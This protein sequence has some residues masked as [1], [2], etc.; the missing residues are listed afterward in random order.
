MEISRML[1][2]IDPRYCAMCRLAECFGLVDLQ[3]EKK[4]VKTA[5]LYRPPQ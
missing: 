1:N 4:K 5:K 3:K 2:G